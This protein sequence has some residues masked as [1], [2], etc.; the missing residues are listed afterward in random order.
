VTRLRFTYTRKKGTLAFDDVIVQG[1]S[2]GGLPAYY[3]HWASGYGLD[4][5]GPNS[6]M[7]GD[8]DGDKVSNIDEYTGG[9][10]PNN[11]HSVFEILDLESLAPARHSLTISAVTDRIYDVYYK[12]NLADAAWTLFKAYTNL[13]AG[14]RDLILTNTAPMQMYRLGVRTP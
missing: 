13:S 4:P 6:E 10:D 2:G 3:T 5:Y 11:P 14:E 9:S 1:L 8:Y 12:T 7:D